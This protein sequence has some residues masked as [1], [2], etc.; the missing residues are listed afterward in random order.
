VIL[1]PEEHRAYRRVLFFLELCI[2]NYGHRNLD[3]N[4]RAYCE[5]NYHARGRAQRHFFEMFGPEKLLP[6]LDFFARV[7]VKRDVFTSERIELKAPLV[8]EDL[9]RWLLERDYVTRD[10]VEAS[11][12]VSSRRSKL[13]TRARRVAR[14]LGERTVT[15]D[16]AFF[17]DR[18][19]IDTDDH[20]VTR[21][22]PG[23]F[24]LRVYRSA[25]PEDIGPLLAPVTA[26]KSLEVG[27]NVCCALARVRGRW[28][29]VA[30]DEI[31]PN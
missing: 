27:W 6:E 25:E 2:N 16:P 13:R 12:E 26:T 4:E 22:D 28:R 21:V 29:I 7:Y 31:Y 17:N 24:W 5:K 15:V 8:V 30:V 10:E 3:A 18:D 23:R 9:K 20:P 1:K 19:Y 11:R 14:L